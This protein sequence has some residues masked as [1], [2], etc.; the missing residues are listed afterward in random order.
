LDQG[1]E[2]L[3][4]GA[5]SHQKQLFCLADRVSKGERL[6]IQRNLRRVQ[7]QGHKVSL[8]GQEPKP[9]G[10]RRLRR[11]LGPG[12]RQTQHEVRD[13]RGHAE[14]QQVH[15]LPQELPQ[16]QVLDDPHGHQLL[17]PPAGPLPPALHR[18]HPA[19]AHQPP[20]PRLHHRLQSPRVQTDNRGPLGVH[21]D[22]L[23]DLPGD[24]LLQPDLPARADDPA[25]GRLPP[26]DHR[27]QRYALL[28]Q[29]W[30]SS[31]PSSSSSPSDS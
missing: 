30:S 21:A 11:L 20:H 4:R 15:S 29:A 25:H 13:G 22:L 19:L 3:F 27:H 9:G 31:P 14:D 16:V 10:G 28:T 12:I 7:L 17:P 23:A 1:K 8:L 2:D 6:H 18:R 5:E 26:R 24:V